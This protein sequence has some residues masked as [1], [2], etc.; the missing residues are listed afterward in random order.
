MKIEQKSY[1]LDLLVSLQNNSKVDIIEQIKKD[2]VSNRPHEVRTS[3][4]EYLKNDFPYGCDWIHP[5][6]YHRFRNAA[7]NNALLLLKEV[8]PKSYKILW[9][10]WTTRKGTKILA[11]GFFYSPTTLKRHCEKAIDILALF[12]FYPDLHIEL[13]EL[14]NL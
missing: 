5:I 2:R 12:L 14:T 3:L 8:N 11:D 9:A 4:L 10:L 1:V 6:T 7:I 13:L